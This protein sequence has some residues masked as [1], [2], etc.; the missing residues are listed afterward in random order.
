MTLQDQ[1][2]D[3][4][5]LLEHPNGSSFEFDKNGNLNIKVTKDAVQDIDG[6]E[7]RNI[8]GNAIIG[9]DGTWTADIKGNI[10][11]T[12]DGKVEISGKLPVKLHSDVSITL[13]TLGVLAP[14]INTLTHPVCKINGQ[15]IGGSMTLQGGS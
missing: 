12:S 2:S 15:P 5:K 14:L 1:D 6:N 9:A 7:T 13:E 8:G 10:K 4:K 11:F 3:L